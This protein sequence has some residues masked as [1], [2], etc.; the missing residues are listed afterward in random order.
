MSE[1]DLKA[2][3][4]KNLNHFMKQRGKIQQDIV[5]DLN[6]SSSL[7]SDYCNGKKF[8]RAGKLQMIADYLGVSMHD[9][10][11]ENIN[12][13]GTYYNST[14]IQGGEVKQNNISNAKEL[15]D[16]QKELLNIFDSLDVRGQ[17]ELILSAYEIRDKY[18][19]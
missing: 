12:F 16:Q 11:N 2:I 18:K 19:Q 7:V 6:L 3:F 5:E 8:P 15:S 9:L 1:K 4:S 17:S 13:N 14:I 10:I